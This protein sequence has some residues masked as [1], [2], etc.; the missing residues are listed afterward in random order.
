[1][2]KCVQNDVSL[3]FFVLTGPDHSAR[4]PPR[5]V[6]TNRLYRWSALPPPPAFASRLN[7]PSEPPDVRNSLRLHQPPP[8]P[9]ITTR[10]S[11]PPPRL[12]QPHPPPVSAT[13]LRYASQRS[14][15]TARLHRRFPPPRTSCTVEWAAPAVTMGRA[16]FTISPQLR[17]P[18]TVFIARSSVGHNVFSVSAVGR[19]NGWG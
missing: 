9:T 17:L 13:R 5:P 16:C 12:R 2:T 7:G 10:L 18:P 4:P 14:V 6:D 15:C 1:M 19:F 8:P 3:S 11:H